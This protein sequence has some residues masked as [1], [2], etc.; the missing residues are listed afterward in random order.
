MSKR[1]L[2][3]L[4][5][6]ECLDLVITRLVQRFGLTRPLLCRT[7][8]HDNRFKH[9]FQHEAELYRVNID[10]SDRVEGL[11]AELIHVAHFLADVSSRLEDGAR[12]HES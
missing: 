6:H 9:R 4:Q 3:T 1:Q 2:K 10:L 7:S 12:P 8:V 11:R 5:I